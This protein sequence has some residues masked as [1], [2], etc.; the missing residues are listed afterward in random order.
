MQTNITLSID[1]E[2]YIK[3]KNIV[4]KQHLKI[5]HVVEKKLIEFINENQNAN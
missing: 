3:F 2:V 4:K 5:S 1:A